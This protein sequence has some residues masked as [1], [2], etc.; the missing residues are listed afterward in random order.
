MSRD[1]RYAV[2]RTDAGWLG[3]LGSGEGL[4]RVTL[5]QRSAEEAVVKLGGAVSQ[6]EHS[7]SFFQGLTERLVMYFNGRETAFP[8]TI[9]PPGTAFQREVWEAARLIPYSQTRS[10]GWVADQIGKPRAA[11][12]VGQA[13]G[14][15]PL[16]VIVPCH[17]VLA[18]DGGLG[19]FTGGVEVKRY[20]LRLESPASAALGK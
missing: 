17:R 19:G 14:E 2:W 4:R 10:Y 8:D 9:A 11:R 6:A 3:V 20:L 16:P 1:L 7:T 15:N 18:G 13:L 12:A 5:P